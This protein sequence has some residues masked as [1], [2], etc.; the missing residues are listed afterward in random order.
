[1][2][3][4]TS[5][6]D[7]SIV[8]STELPPVTFL[9]KKFPKKLM[10]TVGGISLLVLLTILFLIQKNHKS[11]VVSKPATI[12][13]SKVPESMKNNFFYFA[14]PKPIKD[15]TVQQLPSDRDPSNVVQYKDSLWFSGSGSIIEYSTK[16]GELVSYSDPLKANCDRNIVLINNYIYA[17][18][19]ID[20][21]DDAFGHT[22][23]LTTKIYMGAL[24]YSQN[25]S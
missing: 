6:T 10:L 11:F 13:T 9:P 15:L 19:H 25:Q 7:S 14:V 23:Y 21:I 18:C 4:E 24:W 12:L 16:S 1:M 22:N 8:V 5:A 20:N 17:S 3:I 2:D